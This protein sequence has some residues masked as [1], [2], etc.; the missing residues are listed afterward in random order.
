MALVGQYRGP[1]VAAAEMSR[2][3]VANVLQQNWQPLKG[4]LTLLVKRT[5]KR[6]SL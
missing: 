3:E 4:N 5:V 2:L 1:A 6:V